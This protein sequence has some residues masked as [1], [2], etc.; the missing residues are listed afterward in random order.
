MNYGPWLGW[1]I[2]YLLWFQNFRDVSGHVFDKFFSVITMFGEVIIPLIVISVVYWAINK[3]A[4]QFILWSYMCGFVFNTI[5][6]VTACIY[7]PW[8]LDP[9]VHPLPSAIPAA[10]G[11]SF[12]SGHTAGVMSIWGGLAVSFWKNKIFRYLCFFI[13]LSVMV[14][15]NYLGVHTPQDVIVSFIISCFVL[16]GTWSAFEWIEKD[17]KRDK[18]FVAVV[19]A[20]SLFT[21]LYVCL[22]HYPI[23]YLFGKILYD[24][25]SIKYDVIMKSS[26]LWGALAGWITERRFISFN[27]EN[28]TLLR[29]IIR[30]VLGVILLFALK[31]ASGIVPFGFYGECLQQFIIGLFVTAIYPFI[32]KKYNL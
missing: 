24:P 27:P 14:S 26:C 22:K 17:S 4:G 8:M 28:G 13:I 3:R 7:R 10:T 25:T 1:Q 11:Y 30:V 20:L 2:D 18:Y 31:S 9:R 5:A 21:C 16:W 32:I 23:H 15:R 29:K 12:P 19:I 6:K